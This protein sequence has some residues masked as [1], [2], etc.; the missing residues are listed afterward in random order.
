MSESYNRA[1]DGHHRGSE[2]VILEY[3]EEKVPHDTHKDTITQLTQGDQVILRNKRYGRSKKCISLCVKAS[4]SSWMNSSSNDSSRSSMFELGTGGWVFDKTKCNM[5]KNT[6]NLDGE[7]DN[8]LNNNPTV[9]VT[10]GA[11]KLTF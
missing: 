10:L 2:H 9:D 6:L 7:I 3:E 4:A 8:I 1:L 5:N 11:I